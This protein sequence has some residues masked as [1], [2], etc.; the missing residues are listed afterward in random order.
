MDLDAN[1]SLLVAA[2]ERVAAGGRVLTERSETV[3]LPG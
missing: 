2:L 3:L 1:G